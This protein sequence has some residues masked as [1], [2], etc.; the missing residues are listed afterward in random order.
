MA[1]SLPSELNPINHPRFLEVAKDKLR[2]RYVGKGNHAHD[3]G[4]IQANKPVP[5][6]AFVYYYEVTVNDAGSRG[7]DALARRPAAQRAAHTHCARFCAHALLAPRA[8]ELCRGLCR[9]T[10]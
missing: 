10:L 9:C 1:S 7:C 3:V 6:D 4:A 8:Q 2:V 5:S